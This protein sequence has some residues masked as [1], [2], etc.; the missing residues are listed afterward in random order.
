MKI[1]RTVK[2]IAM[3]ILASGI[4]AVGASKCNKYLL[5]NSD[6]DD[7]TWMQGEGTVWNAYMAEKIPHNKFNY[8][9]YVDK[10]Q[11]KQKYEGRLL[12]PDLD[13]NGKVG[14]EE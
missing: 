2:N 1:K 3:I 10:V 7:I 14:K 12:F 9:L 8:S 11:E 6:F 4:I 13:K 5:K